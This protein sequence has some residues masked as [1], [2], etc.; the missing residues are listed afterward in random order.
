MVRAREAEGAVQARLLTVAA[1]R[2]GGA[3][4]TLD[5]CAQAIINQTTPQVVEQMEIAVE[6]TDRR[7]WEIIAGTLI[8]WRNDLLGADFS[9]IQTG[10]VGMEVGRQPWS[11]ARDTMVVR[12]PSVVPV[13]RVCGQGFVKQSWQSHPAFGCRT[14][15]QVWA[16]REHNVRETRRAQETEGYRAT[17][18]PETIEYAM[19]QQQMGPCS[20]GAS[21]QGV[22]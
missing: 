22:A 17:L 9:D 21:R 1:G 18:K 4:H 10:G 15:A 12:E 7:P 6:G 19:V 13:C 3:A 16:N 20:C 8:M 11:R 2:G 5:D 14:C